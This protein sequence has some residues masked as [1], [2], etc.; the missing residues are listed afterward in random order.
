MDPADCARATGTLRDFL[1]H[2]VAGFALT[3]GLAIEL[4][5][6]AHGGKA[7]LRPLNDL[8][9][10]DVVRARASLL[11]L[12]R[13]LLRVWDIAERPRDGSGS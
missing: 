1:R 2:D 6:S 3:G 4:Q 10:R 7:V 11:R 13:K 12:P 5:I 8:D 9:F